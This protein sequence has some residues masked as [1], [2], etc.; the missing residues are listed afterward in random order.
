MNP[1]RSQAF[2]G[3]EGKEQTVSLAEVPASSWIPLGMAAGSKGSGMC[4]RYRSTPLTPRSRCSYGEMGWWW[5][6]TG[7]CGDLEL[8]SSL[9]VGVIFLSWDT[10]FPAVMLP[11]ESTR[12]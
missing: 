8:V 7:A 1:Q 10:G 4:P 2:G 6:G 9:D 12:K 11:A 3:E 5:S